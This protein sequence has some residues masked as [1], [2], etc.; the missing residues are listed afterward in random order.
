MQY[1]AKNKQVF[2]LVAKDYKKFRGTY[3]TDL[4][5]LL[6][7]LLKKRSDPLSF[8]DLGCGVGN[9]TESIVTMAKKLKRDVSVYGC[10]PDTRMLKE[11]RLSAKKNHLAIQYVE[12]SAEK[13]PFKKESFDAVISGAAFH[14]FATKKAMRQV[15]RVL[16]KG[17][18][19]AVFWTRGKKGNVAIG[20]ELYRKYKW[21]GIPQK[22]RDPEEVKKL[23]QSSGFLKVRI[24][25]IP[26]TEIRSI[27]EVI[28][29][30]RTNSTYALLSKEDQKDFVREMTNAYKKVLG[31]KKDKSQE[32]IQVCYGIK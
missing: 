8:L 18:S 6:F 14:W 26:H 29:L 16:K 9:S 2:G 23:F 15:Q 32:E 1:I 27:P 28:G 12:G 4:Y 3:N 21:R 10:D 30:L 13:L 7:S 31:K 22:W 11:A 17:A 20:A 19:Y 25:K 24:V 5:E